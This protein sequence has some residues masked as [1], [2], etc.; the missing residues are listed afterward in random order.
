[1]SRRRVGVIVGAVVIAAG[2]R[3]VGTV[4]GYPLYPN[5]GVR[6]AP[7]KVAQIEGPIFSIDGEKVA[8]RGRVIDVVPGCHVVVMENNVTIGSSE[9]GWAFNVGHVIYA[10]ETKPAHSYSIRVEV[11]DSSGPYSTGSIKARERGPSG[12]VA[13]L[14]PARGPQDIDDC[15]RWAA[16]QGY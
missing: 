4:A 11:A 8:A 1:M 5:S 6:L 2:C 7:D 9:G 12:Q 13:V 3:K 15:R 10:F 14:H 16:K